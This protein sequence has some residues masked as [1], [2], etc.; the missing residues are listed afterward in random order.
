MLLVV[1]T[2][3]AFLLMTYALA[4]AWKLAAAAK[5]WAAGQPHLFEAESLARHAAQIWAQTRSLGPLGPAAIEFEAAGAWALALAALLEFFS[6]AI[7]WL[8]RLQR[9]WGA[10][11]IAL[12]V[13]IYLT[14]GIAFAQNTL[15]LAILLVASPFAPPKAAIISRAE[16]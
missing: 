16:G 9:V 11:L 10:A 5:Q 12:H 8:P 13:G 3:Q 4:G 1:W 15:L 7:P 14:L 2:A 6:C